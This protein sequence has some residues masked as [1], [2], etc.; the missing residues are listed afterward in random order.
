MYINNLQ[1][2]FLILGILVKLITS[3]C[4]V[5]VKSVDHYTQGRANSAPLCLSV[6]NCLTGFIFFVTAT[7]ADVALLMQLGV[8]G[9]FVGSGIFKSDNPK[10]RAWAMAQA[11]TH[12][13]NPKKL[14]ELSE[15]LGEAMFGTPVSDVKHK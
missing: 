3:Q 15:D 1:D 6:R 2:L 8:D 12:Y 7:P 9:V 10:K 13:N 14:A 11:V 5:M 4:I